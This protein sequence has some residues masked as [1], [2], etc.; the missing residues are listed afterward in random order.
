MTPA[1]SPKELR[2]DFG[3][4]QG[5]WDAMI[6]TDGSGTT[7]AASAGWAADIV[8]PGSDDV[9]EL[10]GAF[11]AGTNNV[12]ELMA[13][14]QALLYL[15]EALPLFRESGC[16]VH[17]ISDSSYVVQGLTKGDQQMVWSSQV[18]HHRMLWLGIHGARRLGFEITGHLIP[19][20]TAESNR[21]CH[22]RANL[23][24]KALSVE[25]PQEKKA[26][27]VRSANSMIVKA[28]ELIDQSA[29]VIADTPPCKSFFADVRKKLLGTQEQID[30]NVR[31]SGKQE[32]AIKN[33]CG[34]LRKWLERLAEEAD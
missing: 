23:V 27:D 14:W 22:D 5:S 11:N 8:R 26:M 17:V 3:I 31:V 19:R 18:N 10:S 13:V 12:A 25:R 33:W 7:W 30:K 2:R 34:G 6:I 15:A 21:R 4:K 1:R 32:R 20:D 29:E 24:R 28:I 9:L 16:R